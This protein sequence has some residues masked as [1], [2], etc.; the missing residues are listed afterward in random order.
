MNQ[1]EY[2]QDARRQFEMYKALGDQAISRVDDG[3]FFRQIG[4]GTNSIAILVKHMAG[5]MRSRWT[6]YLDTDG[7]KPDRRRDFEFDIEPSDSKAELMRRWETGWQLLFD[8]LAL[9]E[10]A[11]LDRTIK[12]R[13]QL[14]T[15]MQA[16]NR[17]LTHY[18]YHVGQIVCLAMQLIGPDWESLSVP[19][20]KSKQFNLEMRRK[21]G[22]DE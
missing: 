18:A 16:I 7:E 1:A 5:N 13:S 15:V 17:Q 19:K 4:D 6:D 11:G 3:Q 14:Y 9:A 8:A 10:S 22:S 12:I 21:F 2:L 20:G